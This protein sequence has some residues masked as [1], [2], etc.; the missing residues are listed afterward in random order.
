L[1][2]ILQ[3][4]DLL[5]WG[6][7][8]KMQVFLAEQL[9]PCDVELT[10]VSLGANNRAPVPDLLRSL[11][12]RVVEFPFPKFLSFDSFWRLLTFARREKFDLI[13][14]HLTYSNI[15]GT[16]VGRMTGTPVIASLRTAGYDPRYHRP[17][18]QSIET[19]V[20][21]HG[22]K[23]IMANGR[24]VAELGIK[25]FAPRHIDIL[26]NAIAIPEPLPPRER[27]ELRTELTGDPSRPIV[28]SV[29][30]LD[31]PKG[32]PDLL[33]AFDLIRK[34]QTNAILLIAGDG[35][36]RESLE[37]QV[38]RL[39]LQNH[40]CLLGQRD[41]V[42]RLL[43]AS[44]IYVTSSH[45]EG[46]PVSVLEAMAAGLPVIATTVGEL[47]Y[48]VIR[49]AGSLVPPSQPERLGAEINNLLSNPARMASM[50]AAGREHIRQ[51]FSPEVWLKNLIKLYAQ[52]SPRV[53]EELATFDQR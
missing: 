25:R 17:L 49:Q 33:D 50:G 8:Q 12:V 31:L 9:H 24:V 38:L 46:L 19:F 10:V 27:T 40:V 45:W 18:R 22:A 20:V 15:F 29:G 30:R 2:K 39:G 51:N 21:K 13:H 41:D 5:D 53:G 7:A 1:I 35:P 52:V 3:I 34:T 48:L 37:D 32:F 4:I 44:D 16:L 28:L 26:P 14:A 11:G 43:A 36:L 6:G 42:P 47:P 23:R